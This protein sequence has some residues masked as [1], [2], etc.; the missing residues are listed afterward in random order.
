LQGAGRAVGLVEVGQNVEGVFVVRPADLGQTTSAS[1]GPT[2]NL[3]RA[4][5]P[6]IKPRGDLQAADRTEPSP[7]WGPAQSVTET[8]DARRWVEFL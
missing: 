3:S 6:P 8:D 1:S 4:T 2:S 7:T 5:R